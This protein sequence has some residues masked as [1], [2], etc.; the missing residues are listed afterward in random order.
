MGRTI[1]EQ[2]LRDIITGAAFMGAGGGG[3]PQDGL[4]LLEE[5]VS[6]GKSKLTVISPEEM[7]QD[8]L[9]VMVAEIGAPKV[10]SEVDSFPETVTAF[11]VMQEAA[12]QAG[13]SIK[14]LMAGELG[15]FNTMVPLYVAALK[16]VPFVDADGNGRAVPEMGADLYAAAEV[17][18]SPITMASSSGDSVIINL[19]DPHDHRSAENIA[20]HICLAYGQLA[21]FCTFVVNRDTIIERLAPGTMTL[22]TTIGK[23]FREASRLEG[24]AEDLGQAAGARELFVGTISEVELSSEGGFDLGFTHIDGTGAYAGK[25]VS[26]GFK[27]ENMLMRD[28]SGRV[29]ATVPDVMTLVETEA[30][31]PLTNADTE[32]GQNVA[33]FGATAT[34]NWFRSPKG[35]TNWK[36]ILARFGYEGDYVPVN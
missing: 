3:S 25:S 35:V 28:G 11:T 9:A 12:S 4:K 34:K 24:L 33:V 29:V 1:G 8:E 27:N 6:L 14:Y 21:A 20:R 15:G 22:C 26:I 23:A 7:A 17:P 2:E 30:L 18:H 10:F 31:K 36:P 13:R 16:G 32:K 19:S 5:L